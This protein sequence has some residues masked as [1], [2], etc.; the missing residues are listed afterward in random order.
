MRPEEREMIQDLFDRVGDQGA[1]S[2]DREAERLY[3]RRCGSRP[4]RALCAGADGSAAGGSVAA[5]R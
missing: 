4:E 3:S 5:G 1:E 2:N